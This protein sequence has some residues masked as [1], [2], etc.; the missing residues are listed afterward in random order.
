MTVPETDSETMKKQENPEWQDPPPY[1]ST[2]SL[3][4][5][6]TTLSSDVSLVDDGSFKCDGVE[7]DLDCSERHHSAAGLH[8]SLRSTERAAEASFETTKSSDQIDTALQKK[9]KN[10]PTTSHHI[11]GRTVDRQAFD[12]KMAVPETGLIK[13]ENAALKDPP[14]SSYDYS[15]SRPTDETT[16]S[17]ASSL[18]D[19][20]SFKR[21]CGSSLLAGC[22]AHNHTAAGLETHLHSSEPS[23]VATSDSTEGSDQID[24][25]VQEKKKNQ[26]TTSHVE[27]RTRDSQSDDGK[28]AVPETELMKAENAALKDPPPSSCDSPNALITDETTLSSPASLVDDGSVESDDDDSSMVT[29]CSAHNYTAAELPT[30]S[31]ASLRSEEPSVVANSETTRSLDQIDTTLQKKEKENQPTSSH[32]DGR[33]QTGDCKMAQPGDCKMAVQESEMTKKENVVLKKENV[34]LNN[35]PPSTSYYFPDSPITDET[36]LSSTASLVGDGITGDDG[37]ITTCD[38]I[39]VEVSACTTE[40]DRLTQQAF[41][42]RIIAAEAP[43][44]PYLAPLSEKLSVAANSMGTSESIEYYLQNQPTSSHLDGSTPALDIAEYS[45]CNMDE[46]DSKRRAVEFFSHVSIVFIPPTNAYHDVRQSIWYDPE[47]LKRN[48]ARDKLRR[49]MERVA[50]RRQEADT[51]D[52]IDLFWSPRFDELFEMATKHG[53][54]SAQSMRP[55]AEFPPISIALDMIGFCLG[56]FPEDAYVLELVATALGIVERAQNAFVEEA[57]RKA[58]RGKR[59]PR[60]STSVKSVEASSSMTREE[61]SSKAVS[62]DSGIAKGEQVDVPNQHTTTRTSLDDKSSEAGSSTTSHRETSQTLSSDPPT[63]EKLVDSRAQRTTTGQSFKNRSIDT[64]LSATNGRVSSEASTS[65]S[66]IVEADPVIAPITGRTRRASSLPGGL[67]ILWGLVVAVGVLVFICFIPFFLLVALISDTEPGSN[68][69]LLLVGS[70]SIV[71]CTAVS[72]SVLDEGTWAFAGSVLVGLCV[73]CV[74]WPLCFGETGKTSALLVC[75]FGWFASCYSV[76]LVF[77]LYVLPRV[78]GVVQALLPW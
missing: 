67:A 1:G 59:K 62:S 25:P 73:Q 68:T 19:V 24:T 30:P 20:G 26:L 70:I 38:S 57:K 71:Y 45:E 14:P 75:L 21:D 35:P 69:T 28:I 9:R 37:S 27:G 56:Q 32:I 78:M 64:G 2:N 52:D 6:E 3:I 66:G 63:A 8:S 13:E 76:S 43:L 77:F 65:Q 29:C 16:L 39:I 74:P 4:T 51:D 42:E 48:M 58:K 17:S 72:L 31:S 22:S 41:H 61:S 12:D 15:N 54:D 44:Q 5:D 11:D 18:V 33:T 46:E 53:W 47:E 50:T 36:T 55:G 60:R 7:C 40:N 23:V 49:S 10:Q 34:V